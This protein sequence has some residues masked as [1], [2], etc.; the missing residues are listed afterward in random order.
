M[1]DD[2]RTQ[3][4]SNGRIIVK[5]VRPTWAVAVAFAC[6]ATPPAGAVT[7]SAIGPIEPVDLSDPLS[8]FVYVNGLGNESA[9]SLSGYDINILFDDSILQPQG[10]EF[11]LPGFGSELDLDGSGNNPRNAEFDMPG[12]INVFELSLDS[13]EALNQFQPGE[14]Y[15]LVA[16]FAA[17]T[18]GETEISIEILDLADAGGGSLTADT[19]STT[20]NVVPVPAAAWLFGSALG[21]LGWMKRRT[22]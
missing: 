19:V 9:P 6:L 16:R 21:L 18:L 1:A 12:V 22:A 2:E 4:A 13:E 14:F 11:G 3:G 5:A 15:V 10:I 17:I 8:V 7:L 20:V